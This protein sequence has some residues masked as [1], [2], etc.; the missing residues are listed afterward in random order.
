MFERAAVWDESGGA[1]SESA[2][3]AKEPSSSPKKAAAEPCDVDSEGFD[4]GG[5]SVEEF[6]ELEAY[7]TKGV[8]PKGLVNDGTTRMA[9]KIRWFKEKCGKYV[10]KDGCLYYQGKIARVFDCLGLEVGGCGMSSFVGRRVE[11]EASVAGGPGSSGAL[12]RARPAGLPQRP[13]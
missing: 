8:L 12:G 4:W 11:I 13:E 1:G 5:F 3:K 2:T 7:L 6:A 10:W 9:G